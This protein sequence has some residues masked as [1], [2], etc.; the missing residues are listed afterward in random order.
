MASLQTLGHGGL[1]PHLPQDRH[2]AC[3]V[4]ASLWVSLLQ[5]PSS[6]PAAPAPR[7]GTGR[8]RIANCH[9]LSLFQAIGAVS[10]ARF[11]TCGAC[12]QA[13]R[14]PEGFMLQ[15]DLSSRRGIGPVIPAGCGVLVPVSSLHTGGCNAFKM[16]LTRA[17]VLC[18]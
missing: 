3:S 15:G 10:T 13:Q 6:Q 11:M 4:P 18:R 5:G 12:V 9:C 17:Y 8:N 7:C 2:I 16:L 14:H 1:I